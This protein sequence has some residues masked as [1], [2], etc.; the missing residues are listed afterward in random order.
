ME[1]Q[2]RSLRQGF[3][4]EIVTSPPGDIF[5]SPKTRQLAEFVGIDNI[6]DGVAVAR[7]S[8][9]ATI[10][11]GGFSI[12]AISDF[13]IGD[14]VYVLIRPEDIT[15]T[16]SQDITSARNTF[17]GQITRESLVGPLARIEIDCGFPLL[18]VITKRSAEE[19]KL[20][21]GKELFVSFKA[22]AIRTLE[23]WG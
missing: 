1:N 6:L 4:T 7:E 17:K 16:I 18:A 9:L 11:V 14:K 20:N 19:L 10:D 5:N 8:D 2:R 21:T 3:Y 13:A 22:T 15:L 12:K 23:R